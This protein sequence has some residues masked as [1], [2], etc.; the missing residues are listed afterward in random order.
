[1]LQFNYKRTRQYCVVTEAERER[2]AERQMMLLNCISK[3]QIPI[4]SG[5]Q[6]T[7]RKIASYVHCAFAPT[8]F[9]KLYKSIHA[10]R[11]T[12]ANVWH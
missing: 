6:A 4:L 10:E 11:R 8:T 1:M 9:S 2:V 12:P 3:R 5:F 7:L